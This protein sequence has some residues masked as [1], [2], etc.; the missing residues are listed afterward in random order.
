MLGNSLKALAGL[1]IVSSAAAQSSAPLPTVDLG[2]EVHQAISFNVGQLCL[3]AKPSANM[4]AVHSGFLQLH[5][6]QIRR[7]AG[8]QFALPRA[9][10]GNN[11]EQHRSKWE[12]RCHLPTSEPGVAGDYQH[13]HPGVLV[14]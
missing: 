13:L 1:A 12:R 9:R 10:S 7:T 4:S 14:W 3:A 11:Q 8:G 6:H 2:Y 5:Q